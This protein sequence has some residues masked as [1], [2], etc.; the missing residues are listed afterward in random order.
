[1]APGPA[2]IHP[3]PVSAY[4]LRPNSTLAVVTDA[5][6]PPAVTP[7]EHA[8]IATIAAELAAVDG[9]L[10]PA[11]TR[12]LADLAAH[13]KPTLA[14]EHSRIAELLLQALLR[15]DGIVPERDWNTARA[16]R[17]AA[18]KHIQGLLDQLDA[19]WADST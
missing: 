1:M 7:S 15:V 12:F 14:K 18:V 10:V 9:T 5:D 2:D 3:A 19:A 6:Q 4:H 16:D 17:R 11:H 8:Q 13:P